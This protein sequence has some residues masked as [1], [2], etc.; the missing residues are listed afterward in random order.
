MNEIEI[1]LSLLYSDNVYIQNFVNLFEKKSNSDHYSKSFGGLEF[2]G[3][4]RLYKLFLEKKHRLLNYNQI[5]KEHTIK[6]LKEGN[7]D[8][9]HA[10]YYDDYFL[11]YIGNKPFVIT[12][13]DLI[14]QIFPEYFLGNNIDK[15]TILLK[16]ASKIIAIS[17]STKKDL[18]EF[19]DIPEDKISVIYHASSLVQK[20]QLKKDFIEKI[21]KEFILF[22]GSRSNYKNFYFLVEAFAKLSDKFPSL[23]LVCTGTLFNSN[24]EKFLKNL[25]VRNR[26][27]QLFV[28]DDELIYLYKNAKC[29]VF[30]SLYEGF[31]IPILEAFENKCC[32]LLANNS[33]F[34]EIGGNGAL[35]FE[36]KNITSLIS[37]LEKILLDNQIREKLV[38]NGLQQ[39]NKNF[40]WKKAA[41]ET[42]N[43][44]T[45]IYSK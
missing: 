36:S 42:L 30:P 14:H 19:Y 6:K 1:E 13:H 27:T 31:G 2:R 33:S 8:I 15:N 45:E 35:Y 44:Y 34:F 39:I 41:T 11:E 28:N 43:V 23:N 25:N 40:S 17:H 38:E 26:V 9:F 7:F 12:V 21:P 10:T 20:N 5:N 22:V 4:H 18:I 16:Q 32:T 37:E 29:F 24:E 3:K